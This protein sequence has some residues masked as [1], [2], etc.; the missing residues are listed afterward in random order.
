MDP[1]LFHVDAE[2]LMEVLF[3]I[4]VL[5]I[6]VERGLA[7]LFESRFFVEKLEKKSFKEVIAFAVGALVC[8]GWDFDAISVILVQE[9]MSLYGQI[10]TGAIVA[11]GSKGSIKLFRDML[12]WKSKAYE[13]ANPTPPVP[14]KP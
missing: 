14:A 8:I 2:R 4:G 11:G 3:T 6:L 1:N 13:A 10:I 7:P 9:K 5:A 12:G